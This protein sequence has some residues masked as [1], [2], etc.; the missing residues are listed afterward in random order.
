MRLIPE[1][2]LESGAAGPRLAASGHALIAAGDHTLVLWRDLTLVSTLTSAASLRGRVGLL[3]D[4]RVAWGP[5]AFDPAMGLPEPLP[6][7]VARA[8]H[9]IGP[10]RGRYELVASGI[11][12]DGLDVAVAVRY[13]PP[14]GVRERGRAEEAPAG[15]LVLLDS[16]LRPRALLWQDREL[17][18]AG[19]IDFSPSAVAAG[20]GARV[21]VWS[22]ERATPIATLVTGGPQAVRDLAFSPG[23]EYLAGIT[24]AGRMM[25]WSTS[26]WDLVAPAWEAHDGPGD[27]V[28][29]SPAADL[30]LSAGVGGVRLWTTNGDAVASYDSSARV[31]SA[32]FLADGRIAISYDQDG[33]RVALLRRV[34]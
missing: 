31:E 22:R 20:L 27:C 10:T 23:G 9:D 18:A 16:N 4:G 19:A 13:R 8:T 14:Q 6:D 7:V 1:T 2:T 24:A 33:Y 15:R 11:A 12:G 32:V 17:P 30:V 34:D 21:Q 28:A 5:M 25:V 29:W 26:T 3:G